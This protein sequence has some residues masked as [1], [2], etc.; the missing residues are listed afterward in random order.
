MLVP[1]ILAGGVG[2]RLWPLSREHYPKQFIALLDDSQSLLQSTL[3]RLQGLEPMAGVM[4]ICNQEHRFLVA[5]Q[6]RQIGAQA[7]TIILEPAPRNTAPAV[8]IAAFEAVRADENAVLLI[9]PADHLIR[10][11]DQ[12]QQAVRVGMQAAQQGELVTFGVVPDRPETGFGY[13]RGGA[14][15][16]VKGIFKVEHFAEKPDAATARTYLE[17]GNY[18]WN[19]GMFMFRAQAYLTEL[20]T[21]A[22]DIYEACRKASANTVADLDFQRVDAALFSACRSESIDYAVME[23]TTSAVVVPLQSDWNDVGAWDAIWDVSER[24]KQ[25]NAVQGDVILEDVS[26]SYVRSE[27]RLVAVVSV[28][29]LVVVETNDAVLVAN[30]DNV[31]DVKKIV[32]RLQRESRSEIRNHTRVYRPWGS[33]ETIALEGRFQAKRI[34]VNP[35]ATLSLQLH[36]HRAEHWVIVKGCGLVTRGDET[37]QLNEDQSTYIPIGTRHRLENPGII[38]LEI[39]EVQTGSYLGEDDIVRFDD[40]YGRKT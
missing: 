27:S 32:A 23:K 8:A 38:P 15:S 22:Q 20:E 28:D 25:G 14:E 34:I 26:N 6:L 37:F 36:H 10:S 19:S 11:R 17:S 21:H 16:G 31:Q 35:G 13:I 1:V 30:K 4:V 29:N 9:L 40:Q 7:P 39:I 24:D 18:Y 12:F 3:V 33:Y 2:S 5:E